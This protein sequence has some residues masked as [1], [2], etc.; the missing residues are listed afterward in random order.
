MPTVPE[1]EGFRFFFYSPAKYL[2]E[3]LESNAKAVNVTFTEDSLMIDME[4]L[5]E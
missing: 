4:R 3:K 5:T 2:L 1:I